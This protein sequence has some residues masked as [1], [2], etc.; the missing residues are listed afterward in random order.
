MK[1]KMIALFGWRSASIACRYS[2]RDRAE[3]RASDAG[4]TGADNPPVGPDTSFST[5]SFSDTWTCTTSERV[6]RSNPRESV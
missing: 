5:K 6:A 2:E 3:Q 4:P 1:I